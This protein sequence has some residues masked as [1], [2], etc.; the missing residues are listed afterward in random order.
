MGMT[1]KLFKK[2]IIGFILISFV[3]ILVTNFILGLGITFKV[4]MIDFSQLFTSIL[5]TFIGLIEFIVLYLIGFG[6]N[7]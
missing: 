4:G 6:F 3:N 1:K 7:R 5:L 2:L